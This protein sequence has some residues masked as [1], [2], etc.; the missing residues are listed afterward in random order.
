LGVGDTVR[1][2][3][4][5]VISI[6][7]I[8]ATGLPT[9]AQVLVVLFPSVYIHVIPSSTEAYYNSPLPITASVTILTPRGY[10]TLADGSVSTIT[11]K[12]TYTLTVYVYLDTAT[13]GTAVDSGVILLTDKYLGFTFTQQP[14]LLGFTPGTYIATGIVIATFTTTVKGTP[15]TRVTSDTDTIAVTLIS[16]T[17]TET[18]ETVASPTP[19]VENATT[20]QV[21]VGEQTYTITTWTHRPPHKVAEVVYYTPPE[22]K[23]AITSILM[24]SAVVIAL[25]LIRRYVY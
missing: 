13:W 5:A 7:L 24:V 14:D 11:N 21:V 20:S 19:T 2:L 25:L 10:T 23:L 18:E 17:P 16:E 15:T 9:I 8:I 12:Y 3:S 4:L 1:K 22:L 6:V